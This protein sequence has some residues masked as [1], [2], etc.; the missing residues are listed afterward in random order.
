[1]VLALFIIGF[2]SIL[3]QVVLLRELNVAFYGS[4]LIYTLAL[5][6]WLLWTATGAASGRRRFVPTTLQV[7]VLLL[8]HHEVAQPLPARAAQTQ[9]ASPRQRSLAVGCPFSPRGWTS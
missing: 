2:L 3:G 5:G 9:G 8:L 6:F 1:M 4:E 7:R